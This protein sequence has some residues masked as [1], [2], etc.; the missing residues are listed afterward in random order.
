MAKILLSR[1]IRLTSMEKK[2]NANIA[3][4]QPSE[5]SYHHIVDQN[6]TDEFPKDISILVF[7]LSE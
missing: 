6:T 3:D 7:I 5:L 4:I 2:T 1:I